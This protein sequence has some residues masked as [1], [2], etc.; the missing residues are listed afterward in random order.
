MLF[1]KRQQLEAAI[2]ASPGTGVWNTRLLP[3]T[4]RTV[5]TLGTASS[6]ASAQNTAGEV[7]CVRTTLEL[8]WQSNRFLEASPGL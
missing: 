5:L 6:V 7:F 1:T 4:T 8:R 3:E 2:R